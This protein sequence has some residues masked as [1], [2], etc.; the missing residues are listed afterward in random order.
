MF[1]FERERSNSMKNGL[2]YRTVLGKVEEK[3]FNCILL[4]LSLHL[5]SRR[6]G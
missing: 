5:I 6:D 1:L 3:N 4:L 2:S